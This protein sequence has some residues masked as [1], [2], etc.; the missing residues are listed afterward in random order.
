MSIIKLLI[1][2]LIAAT[3][4]IWFASIFMVLSFR[5]PQERTCV[6]CGG[7]FETYKIEEYLCP[8]CQEEYRTFFDKSA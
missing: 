8:V 3:L 2:L 4:M 5:K 1:V 7:T 6:T